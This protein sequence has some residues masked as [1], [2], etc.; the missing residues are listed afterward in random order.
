MAFQRDHG[1][2][3]ILFPL[4][5]GAGIISMVVF[6]DAILCILACFTGDIR[7]QPNG[8]NLTVYRLPAIVGS[9]GILFGFIGLLGI[10]DD[11]LSWV[12]TFMNYFAVKLLVLIACAAAD[13]YT[14]R[15]C[16]GWKNSAEKSLFPNVQLARLSEAD[17]CP[18]AR[19]SYGL[20]AGSVLLLWTYC[21]WNCYTYMSHIEVNPAYPLDFGNEKYHTQGRWRFFQV[22]DPRGNMIGE[23]ESILEDGEEATGYGAT[24]ESSDTNLHYGPDGF[25]HKGSKHKGSEM[26]DF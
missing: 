26:I 6:V 12:R 23:H 9:A 21:F 16:E 14:L 15:K 20:G 19:F 13:F 11:K 18:W 5:M 7:F 22:K 3:C 2:C 24:N 25:K 8:Y 1:T 4:K 17:V 10:Y